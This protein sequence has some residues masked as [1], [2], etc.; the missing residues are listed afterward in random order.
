MIAVVL[1][2]LLWDL[3]THFEITTE[4]LK[5]VETPGSGSGS[6]E[7]SGTSSC[8]AEKMLDTKQWADGNEKSHSF[9]GR[10][11]ENSRNPAHSRGPHLRALRYAAYFQALSQEE[12]ERLITVALSKSFAVLLPTNEIVHEFCAKAEIMAYRY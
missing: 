8:L 7:T 10:I 3:G 9:H 4:D 1:S 12:T 11:G 2:R 6:S 5:M